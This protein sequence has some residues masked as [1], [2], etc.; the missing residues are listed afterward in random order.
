MNQ[1]RS[2]GFA[3]AAVVAAAATTAICF[4]DAL[5]LVRSSAKASEDIASAPFGATGRPI[6]ALEGAAPWLTPVPGSPRALRGKVVIVNFW[7]YSCI[8]SLR[9][10][11]Y[12]RAWSERYG[13]KGLEVVGVHA[14]EFGF[15]KNPAN[16]R[17]AAGQL[18]VRY[19]NLQDNDYAVWRDF[20]NQGWPGIYFIDAKGKVRGYRLGEGKYDEG[21]RL[22]RT[23]LAEAGQDVSDI[24][25]APIES[26]GVEAQADWA[27]LRSP[28]A[29][30][31]YDKA[32]DF[33]SPGGL[34]H[35]MAHAYSS[36]ADLSLNQWDLAGSWKV[37]GEYALLE[38]GPGT[39]R[40]RFHARDAHLV[41]GGAPD[42]Q[43]VRFRVTIDGRAPGARHGVDVDAQGWGQVKE[44][45]LYQLVRQPGMIAD[46]TV[47]I[48]FARPGVRA[49]VFT[50]G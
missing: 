35:D 27:D 29:Y 13:D 2:L 15:E 34:K 3:A 5:G 23:L 32:V 7:T 33:A 16:V 38:S 31:G 42:G 11:P 10:L 44:D 26:K 12:L 20:A 45:R 49:Y 18:D 41:L 14:P 24:P 25:L 28:E 39:I 21:E 22:I 17:L 37:G 43:P 36:A 40:F 8:N 48:E 46:R 30:I 9:A 50:F 6:D 19:P 1:K 4:G 47:T